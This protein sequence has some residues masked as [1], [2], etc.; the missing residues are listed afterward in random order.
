MSIKEINVKINILFNEW[1]SLQ[2]L[3][4]EYEEKL[5]RKIK[6]EWNYNSNH[7][8]GNTLTY[9]ETELLL[10]HGR[11]E[12]GHHERNYTEMKAHDLAIEKIKEFAVD[13][14][15]PLTE[16][17]IR[18]LNEIILKEPFFKKAQMP[19]GQETKKKI[20]PGD[21]KKNPTMS[22]PSLEKPLNLLNLGKSL[23]RWRVLQNGSISNYPILH[24]RWPLL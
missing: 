5:N 6:L 22:K 14:G 13:K 9:G 2:P 19:D 1:K 15:R 20:I 21:Y 11:C 10:I 16:A 3:R 12:G 7:I 18:G 4:K 24:Y 23:R 17:D 8:E